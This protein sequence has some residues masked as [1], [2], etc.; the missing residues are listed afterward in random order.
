MLYEFQVSIFVLT[1]HPPATPPRQD[2]RL[3]FTFVSDGVASAVR[4]ARAAAGER[5]VQVVGGASVI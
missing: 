2:H 1:H 5:D 3:T 4:L